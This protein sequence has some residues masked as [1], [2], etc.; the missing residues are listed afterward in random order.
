MKLAN[1]FEIL[2]ILNQGSDGITYRAIDHH[3]PS[4]P[5]CIIHEFT[6]TGPK[7]LEQLRQKARIL[8]ILGM[9][10]RIPKLL[11]YFAQ[12]QKFYMS[13]EI[14]HGHVLS[15]EIKAGKPLDESYVTKLL[16][17]ILSVLAFVHQHQVVHRNIQPAHLIR[18]S[19]TGDIFL[20]SFGW[21]KDIS[22]RNIDRNGKTTMPEWH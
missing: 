22:D 18:Q 12:D 1:R 17:D 21:T 10:S 3:Q 6:Y 2:K 7:I 8:E 9:H 11:A 13:Q 4:R 20:T 14:I 15:R 5:E 19:R 16:K